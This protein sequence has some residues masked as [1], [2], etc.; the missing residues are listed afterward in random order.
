VPSAGSGWTLLAVDTGETHSHTAN[1]YG[2]R[3][4]ACE[5]AA[6]A[7]GVDHLAQASP[8]D[9]EG[10]DLPAEVSG[11]ARHVVTEEARTLAGV[12]ALREGDMEE[13]GRLMTAS[14]RSMQYDFANST[15]TMDRVVDSALDAG[16]AGARMTGG[17]WGGTAVV[18]VGSSSRAAVGDALAAVL[19]DAGSSP[20]VVE[21][22]AGARR[23]S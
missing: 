3:R 21:P 14:H 20:V 22:S 7:L 18:L 17:G 10:A 6:A 15:P 23:I 2:A 13:F 19:G 12:Q 16:A 4:R 9:V 1:L 5:A 8:A 11:P